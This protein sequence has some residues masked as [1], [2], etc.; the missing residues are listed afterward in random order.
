ME[1]D[2]RGADLVQLRFSRNYSS[3]VIRSSLKGMISID[4]KR[5]AVASQISSII[6][7]RATGCGPKGES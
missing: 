7:R 1:T 2:A 6:A 4:R 5:R 3:D